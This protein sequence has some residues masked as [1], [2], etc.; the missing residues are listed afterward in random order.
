MD[1]CGC[2][3]Q[4]HQF[5]DVCIDD[6]DLEQQSDEFDPDELDEIEWDECDCTWNYGD[7]CEE[8]DDEYEAF[9]EEQLEDFL[10]GEDFSDDEY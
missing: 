2:N 8:C 9:I 3:W 1:D 10:D 4:N 5:C 6:Y 7:T